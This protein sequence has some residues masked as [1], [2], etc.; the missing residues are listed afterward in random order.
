MHLH[1]QRQPGM[2]HSLV[3]LPVASIAL[4]MAASHSTGG[5]TRSTFHPSSPTCPLAKT[6]PALPPRTPRAAPRRCAVL[7]C[8]A[9]RKRRQ[10]HCLSVMPRAAGGCGLYPQL[11]CYL[12]NSDPAALPLHSTRTP[13]SLYL[14]A[15][16]L[17]VVQAA[18][19]QEALEAGA[20][21][22]LVDEDTS[23]TNCESAALFAFEAR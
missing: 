9:L 8:A 22:L 18:N 6:P 3:Q 5:W 12:S 11:S 23:A 1:L 20:R 4:Q 10:P 19:I 2:N 15:P 16:A 21:T 7:C 13:A 14:H 17:F